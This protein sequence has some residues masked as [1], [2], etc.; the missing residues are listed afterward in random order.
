[1]ERSL[2]FV[3]L[4]HRACRVAALT[5][6]FTI[7]GSEH[8]PKIQPQ[9]GTLP[10]A[11]TDR[12]SRPVDYSQN[13]IDANLYRIVTGTVTTQPQQGTTAANHTQNIRRA[14]QIAEY[15]RAGLYI[16]GYRPDHDL[17]AMIDRRPH[18]VAGIQKLDLS[19]SQQHELEAGR[20]HR[21]SR[22]RQENR[23]DREA[24]DACQGTRGA[25]RPRGL[26]LRPGL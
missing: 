8:F 22:I 12:S 7:P 1:M 14:C 21:P 17:V 23:H 5:G 16:V 2:V 24:G 20:S 6:R 10:A 11:K 13:R 19:L 25:R 18:P 4:T 15:N 3:L 26:T 9:P